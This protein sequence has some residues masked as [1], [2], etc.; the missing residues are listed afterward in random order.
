LRKRKFPLDDVWPDE[1]GDGVASIL[2]S[3]MR[4]FFFFQMGEK[5]T[6]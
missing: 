2:A 6:E 5:P 1:E 3:E 4:F